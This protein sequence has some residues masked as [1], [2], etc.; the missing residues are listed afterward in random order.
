M[1]TEAFKPGTEP[2]TVAG[3][4]A[5]DDYLNDV[6]PGGDGSSTGRP[7]SPYGGANVPGP[8]GLY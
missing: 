1:I 6:A 3:E 8:G 7:P 5:Y 2:T 4:A